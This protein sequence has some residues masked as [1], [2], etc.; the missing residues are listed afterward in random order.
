M[1][2]T[3]GGSATRT[4]APS[5]AAAKKPAS[6]GRRTAPAPPVRP[7][8]WRVQAWDLWAVALITLGILLALALWGRQLGPVGS[9]T[10]TGLALLAGW[11]RALLP[12]VAAGAGVAL[13]VDR[14]PR[15]EEDERPDDEAEGTDPW[16][17]AVGIALG[18]I[19]VCGL[20]EL[21]KHTPSF[22][23]Q[24]GLKEAGG[25]LG[26]LAG[27][28]LHA[29]LG[30]A[31]AAVLLVA[32]VLVAILIATGVSIATAARATGS[33]AVASGRTAASLWRGKPFVVMPEH[34]GSDREEDALRVPPPGPDDDASEPPEM[35]YDADIDIPLDPEPEPEP[36]SAAESSP[37][38][39]VAARGPGEW[40]LPPMSKLVA[41]KKLRHD[42]RQVDAAGEEL[43]RALAAHGVDTRLVGSRVGPTVTRYELELGPGVKVARVT[44][45]SKDIAYAMASPDV[46]ILAPIPGKSAIGVEVP[47][48][49]RQLVALRDILDSKE[50]N[51]AT[52]PL[53]VAMGRD[54]AGRAV[55][56]NL[57]EMPH[58]LIS[59]AT[60][61]GKSSCMNSII[62][63]ILMRDTPDRVK[64]ILVDPKRVELGQYDGLPHLLN[65]VVVDPKQAANALAWAVKEM[66]RRYGLLAQHGVRDINGYNQLV[67]EGRI[68]SPAS[69]RRLVRDAAARALGADHPAVDAEEDLEEEEPVQPEPFIL[70]VVDELNDLMM[71]AARDV[72]DSI[73]RIAQMARAVGIHLV[74]ATQRPSVDVITGVIKANIPS[75]MAFSV[76][77]LADSRVILDQPGAERLVGKGDM[78][79]LTAS[80]NIPRRLQAPWVS[81]EEVRDI[82]RHWK[83]Q[84]GQAEAIVAFEDVNDG[85][86]GIDAMD[87]EEDELLAQARDLV[88][89]SQLGST[90]MLQRKLRVGFARAGR[91][92]DLLEQAGVVG[93][94]EGSKARA[95]LMTPEE[96]DA[97]NRR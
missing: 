86:G 27:R 14:K 36:E 13:L 4:R 91:L 89:R 57:A 34:D 80:S 73:V 22:S 42:Q 3:R 21:A 6:R 66:E 5:R 94:S 62:T 59:G 45:L 17:L 54:I 75:R 24:Q 46:R 29:G 55:M 15:G 11:V 19:G 41:S 92:M 71:V 79:L 37:P 76:S 56:E 31:G 52:H 90:S 65:P 44:S 50:G 43:V 8:F 10:D 82:V 7:R 30:S 68:E 33:A 85:R 32:V 77:S 95:V 58:I 83:A 87:D 38:H 49:T 40:V 69:D 39:P 12:L 70:V 25:Y 84:G 18:L 81:E 74:I 16:R 2:K 64:M 72:E 48:R 20:A 63:S 93:P 51:A 47:N 97:L 35:D 9:G 78:L 53:E 60:G 88:V 26:A 23:N 96:L 61:S 67:A 1:T 28:P